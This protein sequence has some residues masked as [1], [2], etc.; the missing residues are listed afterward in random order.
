MIKVTMT[1]EFDEET[2]R[3]FFEGCEV[4]FSKKK[5]KEL[6]EDLDYTLDDVQIEMEESFQEIVQERITELFE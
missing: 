4:K 1:F 3:D 2:L 5:V 6:Q